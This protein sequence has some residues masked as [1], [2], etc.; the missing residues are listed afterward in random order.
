MRVI[1][2]ILLFLFFSRFFQGQSKRI[3]SLINRLRDRTIQ[4]DGK[5]IGPVFS[6][7]D[8]TIELLISEGKQITPKLVRL[9]DDRAKGIAVHYVL[10]DLY[11]LGEL[12][13]INYLKT[14]STKWP[15]AMIS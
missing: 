8:N 7:A 3:D 6:F 14:D 5:W 15:I 1:N 2:I 12:I 9:L 4:I 13:K 11:G 10:T